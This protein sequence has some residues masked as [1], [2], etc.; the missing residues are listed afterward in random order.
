MRP[1]SLLVLAFGSLILLAAPGLADE[2]KGNDEGPLAALFTP[3]G[4]RALP[5]GTPE[6]LFLT[7]CSVQ[8]ECGDSSVIS[9]MG[10]TPCSTGGTN[11]NCVFCSGSQ[12]ACCPS[13]PTCCQTCAANRDNCSENCWSPATCRACLLGYDYCIADC[14]GGCS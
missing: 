13:G 10:N 7:T 11:D 6:P 14:T 12:Q 2:A 3:A 8:L 4:C 1:N 9:C 5:F